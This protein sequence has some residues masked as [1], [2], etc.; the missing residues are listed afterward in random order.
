MFALVSLSFAAP[1]PLPPVSAADATVTTDGAVHLLARD[2]SA[3]CWWIVDDA[4]D[5]RVAARWERTRREAVVLTALPDGRAVVVLQE[6][7]EP[8]RC[9]LVVRTEGGGERPL[10]IDLPARPARLFAHV[11]RPLV[12]LVWAGTS[13]AAVW[14]VDVDAGRTVAAAELPAAVTAHLGF[15]VHSD[16]LLVDGA[17]PAIS[18]GRDDARR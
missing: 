12:A 17:G 14:L 8:G 16:A 11:E 6:P 7:G 4:G 5:A 18:P 3:T 10:S 13:G 2:A 9:R 1:C 15:A